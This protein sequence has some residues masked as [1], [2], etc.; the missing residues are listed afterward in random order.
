V[1]ILFQISTHNQG[2]GMGSVCS[3]HLGEEECYIK[4]WH[5][6]SEGNRLPE[7]SS[8]RWKD[9]IKMGLRGIQI[10]WNLSH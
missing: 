6:N 7:I 8:R 9:N 5:E 3:L 2:D 4:F 1:K 10:F